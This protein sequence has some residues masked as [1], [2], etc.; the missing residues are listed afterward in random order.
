M[1]KNF[2]EQFDNL[3]KI[4]DANIDTLTA[5]IKQSDKLSVVI[6]SLEEKKDDEECKKTIESL[7]AIRSG[8]SKSIEELVSQT[9][10]LFKTY[11]KLVD[12]VF[13]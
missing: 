7:E 9:R 1:K 8:I 3:K 2:K 13:K 12:E 10:E 4:I 5:L 6:N 11:D